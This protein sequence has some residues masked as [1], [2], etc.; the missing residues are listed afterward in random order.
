M[1]L[2]IVHNLPLFEP[3]SFFVSSF[4]QQFLV[5]PP[6]SLW[7]LG[8]ELCQWQSVFPSFQLQHCIHKYIIIVTR[9]EKRSHFTQNVSILFNCSSCTS[10]KN[11]VIATSCYHCTLTT[12]SS[13]GGA[14]TR[15]VARGVSE[16]SEN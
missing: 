11:G 9:F 4:A 6:V 7:R 3:S 1:S 16:V 8:Q 14:I 13:V 2:H 12:T 15:G 5:C 10:E